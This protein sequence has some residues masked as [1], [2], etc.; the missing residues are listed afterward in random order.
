[1]LS[2]KYWNRESTYPCV[3][4]EGVRRANQFLDEKAIVEVMATHL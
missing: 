3:S 4:Q 1:M 2:P